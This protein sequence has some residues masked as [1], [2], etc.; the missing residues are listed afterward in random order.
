ML[1]NWLFALCFC[2]TL[3][4]TEYFVVDPNMSPYAGAYNLKL[5]HSYAEKIDNKNFIGDEIQPPSLWKR[6]IEMVLWDCFNSYESVIQHEFFGHGYRLRDLSMPI[7]NYTIGINQ[8]L[9]VFMVYDNTKAGEMLAIDVAG[10]EAQNI[11]AHQMKMQ[12]IKTRTIDPRLSSLYTSNHLSTL[13]YIFLTLDEMNKQQTPPAANDISCFLELYNATYPEA[14]L[15]IKALANLSLFSLLDP[16]SFYSYYSYFS[17]ILYGKPGR[18]PMIEVIKDVFYLPNFKTTL[19]PYG[20]EVYFENYFLFGDQPVYVY[21]KGGNKSLGLGFQC[22][23]IYSHKQWN[24]GFSLDF[25][26]HNQYLSNAT[27]NDFIE[28]K[29]IAI[30]WPEGEILGASLVLRGSTVIKDSHFLFV[31]AGAKTNGYLPGYPLGK[32]LTLRLGTNF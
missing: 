20:P 19:A 28:E 11:L 5:A 7:T 9:T 4:A 29:S 8:G 24:L 10:L 26:Q 12:W 30:E 27:Y 21:G 13:E 1:K 6:W 23:E 15:S 2:S 22:D 3:T 18:V 16:M 32:A 31:E 14:S 25:W 17:Y